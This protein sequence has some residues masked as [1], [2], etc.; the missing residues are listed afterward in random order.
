MK[1]LVKML[2][3]LGYDKII[4]YLF[5]YLPFQIRLRKYEK[6]SK[7]KIKFVSQ[8]G[9]NFALM[10]DLKKFKIHDSSHLK[11]DAVIDCTGGVEIGQYFHTGRGLTIFST[12]HD[13]ESKCKIPYNEESIIAPVTIKDFVWCGANVT[14]V[15]GVT[16]GEGAVIGAGAVVTKDVPEHAVVGG[17]PA[18]I[19]K[20]RNVENFVKLKKEGKFF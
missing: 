5:E 9:Y 18:K 13:F 7:Q 15:P 19:L 8:G 6:V 17:N 11:S 10:G 1:L 3:V 4:F 16:I 20:Y 12:N 2:S 14:I